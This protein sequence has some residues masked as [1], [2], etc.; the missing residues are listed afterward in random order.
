MTIATWALNT[1]GIFV[2]AVGAL[3]IVLYLW[4]S[5]DV[6]DQW[7]S[8]EGKLAYARHRRLLIIGV[9]LL[10]AQFILQYLGVLLV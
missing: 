9:S 3:L 1:A 6:V 5:P 10:A 4:K 2:N 7:L 8:P